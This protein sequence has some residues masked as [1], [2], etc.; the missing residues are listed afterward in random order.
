MVFTICVL[1]FVTVLM[2]L[3]SVGG[4][5]DARVADNAAVATCWLWC[6]LLWCTGAEGEV[7]IILIEV[8]SYRSAL[9]DF[10][11]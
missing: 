7:M 8:V 3:C 4:G 2:R 10:V 1:A 11:L 9:Y 6:S 5:G